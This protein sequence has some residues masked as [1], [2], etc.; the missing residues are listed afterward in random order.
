MLFKKGVYPY[1]YMENRERF[2]E[3]TLPNKEAFDSELYLEDIID[4]HYIHAQKVFKEFNIKNL[5]E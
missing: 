3:A 4:E 1:E 2:D 5:G